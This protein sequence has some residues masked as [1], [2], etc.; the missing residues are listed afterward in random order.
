MRYAMDAL[1]RLIN[2]HLKKNGLGPAIDTLHANFG[3]F[4]I[5]VFL[6]GGFVRSCLAS[7]IHGSS[8]E[9]KDADIVVDTDALESF[10]QTLHPD[11]FSR[12]QFGGFRWQPKRGKIWIDI[13]QLQD[14]VY[15]K[16]FAMPPTLES[17]LDGVDLNIDRLAV[18]LH[19][20]T[21]VAD[22]SAY[23][24]IRNKIID[25]DAKVQMEDFLPAELARAVIAH[26]K[27]GYALSPKVQK[28]LKER[29]SDIMM[30]DTVDRLEADG[31]SVEML[32]KVRSF[33]AQV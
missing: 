3:T 26:L 18:G 32:R 10:M 13:W 1:W 31:Y 23:S 27:T 33:V 5:P 24:G 20:G 8:I 19:D 7:L 12:T 4:D 9:P 28:L 11:D 14:T 25:L 21:V 2:Y 15:I 30:K 6:V 17:F 16:R 22:R 29:K